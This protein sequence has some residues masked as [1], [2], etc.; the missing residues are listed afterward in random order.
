MPIL[1]AMLKLDLRLTVIAGLCCFAVSCFMDTG[2]TAASSGHDFLWTQLLRGAGQIL[3]FMPLNQA[4]VG[5]VGMEDAADAAGLYN[6]ARNLGGSMGLALLGVFI[7]RQTVAHVQSIGASV[8]ANSPLAQSQMAAQAAGFA[9]QSG[10]DLATGQV[11]A[12]TQ[13]GGTVQVQ[14][15]VMTYGDCFFVLGVGLL[16]MIPLVFLLRPPPKGAPQSDLAH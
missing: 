9:S 10:G 12:L 16:F 5:A 4:S 13:L 11:Q 6:M 15:M 2:L 7:D 3:T 14:A 8:T 1:P